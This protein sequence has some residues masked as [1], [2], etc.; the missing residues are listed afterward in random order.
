MKKII[1]VIICLK[2]AAT[3]YA[4]PRCHGFNNYDDKVTIVLVDDKA[5]DKYMVTEAVLSTGS[6]KYEA[7]SEKTDMRDGVAVVTLTF[8]HDTQFSNPKLTLRVN[9]K[10]MKVKICQ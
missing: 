10:K 9:G 6:K 4:K 7:K 2:V 3:T 1:F 8:P 5:G